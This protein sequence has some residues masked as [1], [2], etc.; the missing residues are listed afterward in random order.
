MEYA[1]SAL[2]ADYVTAAVAADNMPSILLSEKL[3]LYPI[4]EQLYRNGDQ[5]TLYIIYGLNRPIHK[6]EEEA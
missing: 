6:K 4:Q 3:G 1:F 5:E 2:D